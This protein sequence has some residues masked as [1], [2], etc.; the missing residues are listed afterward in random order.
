MNINKNSIHT[1]AGVD[2]F[3]LTDESVMEFSM[4]VTNWAGEQVVNVIVPSRGVFTRKATVVTQSG[5]RFLVKVAEGR[6]KSL[7]PLSHFA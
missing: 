5:R 1:M 4:E 3:N 7:I 6:E 2:Y